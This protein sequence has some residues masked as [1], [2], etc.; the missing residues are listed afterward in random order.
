MDFKAYLKDAWNRHGNEPE[1][2]FAEFD[3][4][5]ELAQNGQDLAGWAG[6]V[7][8]VAG[9]H[10]GRF[11]DGLAL[12]DPIVDA[13]ALVEADPFRRAVQRS[14]AI[15]LLGRGDRAQ[16]ESL[17]ADNYAV[18]WP[19]ASSKVRVFATT[20]TAL[21]AHEGKVDTVA[22]LVRRSDSGHQLRPRGRRS[23]RKGTRDCRQQPCDGSRGARHTHRCAQ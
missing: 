21:A 20:S 5:R 9:E 4:G 8:H 3:G 17:L 13:P 23:R 22:R 10:L 6:L 11:S 15:L 7:T 16:A 14:R 2:V 12:L 1:T 18:D 19:I